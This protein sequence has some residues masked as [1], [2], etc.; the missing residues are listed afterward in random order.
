M[1]HHFKPSE[2]LLS[3]YARLMCDT[4]IPFQEAVLNDRIDG[5]E[6]SH[7]IENFE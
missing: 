6:P 5:V 4:V 1:L 7:A 3:H 2:G